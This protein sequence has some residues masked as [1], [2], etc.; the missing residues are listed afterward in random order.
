MDWLWWTLSIGL[1]AIG[2]AGTFLPM[3]PGAVL[4]LAGAA[5]HF[6]G[7]GPEHSIGWGTL[8]GLVVLTLISI[9]IDW[10]ATLVG[11]RF[12]GCSRFGLWCGVAG[13]FIGFVVGWFG[14]WMG[15]P[16]IGGILGMVLGV[17]GGEL[18]AKRPVREAWR[19]TVGTV[20]GAGAGFVGKG[21]I[22]FVMVGWFVG[23]LWM[24]LG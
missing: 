4:I 8:M 15:G 16:V 9:G 20:L 14:V 2:L 3:L 11:A 5:V 21:L 22:S 24:R 17:F 6:L 19:A 1:M 18:L 13:G 10:V 12:F 7:L 23:A